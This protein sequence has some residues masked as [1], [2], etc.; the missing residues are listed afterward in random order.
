MT[1]WALAAICRRRWPIVVVGCLLTA[2]LGW[3]FRTAPGVYSSS[4]KVLF[5]SPATPQTRLLAPTS[6][7]AIPFV[8]VIERELNAGVHQAPATAPDVTLVD[9]GILDGWSARQPDYGGQ[10][11]H[12]FTEATLILQVSG[13]TEAVVRER[14]STLIGRTQQI[15]DERQTSVIPAARVT[16]QV[17]GTASQ[18]HFAQGRPSRAMIGVVGIGV[19]LTL[20]AAAIFDRLRRRQYPGL[21]GTSRDEQ[22]SSVRLRDAPGGDQDGA[23]SSGD[24]QAS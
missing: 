6:G 9:Q 24:A 12:N 21:G 16:M 5:L 1:I 13:P 14:M 7:D 2:L 20:G 23:G 18:V 8:G 4:T 22:D 3:N 19:A 11:A 17:S 10:W 15:L